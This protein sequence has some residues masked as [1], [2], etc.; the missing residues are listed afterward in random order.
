MISSVVF[1]MNSDDIC[2]IS[3]A[4]LLWI[5]LWV[6]EVEYSRKF[7]RQLPGAKSQLRRRNGGIN[8][9]LIMHGGYKSRF[10]L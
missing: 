1:I 7:S 5:N 4:I 6:C 2:H 10:K 3:R 8:H 9:I